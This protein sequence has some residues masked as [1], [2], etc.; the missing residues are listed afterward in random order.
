MANSVLGF[1]NFLNT[2]ISYLKNENTAQRTYTFP[3]RD[4]N[5]GENP[6]YILDVDAD[7]PTTL[8]T[9]TDIPGLS[10]NL[11]AN[12][13]YIVEGYIGNGCNNTGGVRF[14]FVTPSGS[15][16]RLMLDGM[17]SG[18]TAFARNFFSADG[19]VAFSYTT[20]NTSGNGSFVKI[21]GKITV[22]ANAGV[23]KL[24]FASGTAGQTSTIYKENSWMK[25]TKVS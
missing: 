3:D 21:N 25:L 18:S 9:A 14:G 16:Y 2:I 10:I 7:T 15:T 11:E 6:E 22:G 12:S 23:F 19:I 24:Q 13:V 17:T 5:F 8:A 20:L 1:P 4:V